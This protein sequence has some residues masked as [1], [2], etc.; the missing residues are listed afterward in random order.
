MNCIIVIPRFKKPA[1]IK[2]LIDFGGK[3]KK[4]KK[5]SAIASAGGGNNLVS[6]AQQAYDNFWPKVIYIYLLYLAFLC[7]I[8]PF[9]QSDRL[10]D[11]YPVTFI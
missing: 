3:L 6:E 9:K 1:Q 8:W 7:P 2:W 10:T 4:T 11:T 5:M